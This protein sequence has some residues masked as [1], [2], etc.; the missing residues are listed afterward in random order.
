MQNKRGKNTVFLTPGFAPCV[1]PFWFNDQKYIKFD[2]KNICT[3]P[4]PLHFPQRLTG[5]VKIPPWK[6]ASLWDYSSKKI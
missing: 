5:C 2:Y 1:V 6:E 4:V 3:L